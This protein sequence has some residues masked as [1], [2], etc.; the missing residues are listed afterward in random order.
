MFLFLDEEGKD[1]FFK[2]NHFSSCSDYVCIIVEEAILIIVY[3]CCLEWS[4]SGEGSEVRLPTGGH[5]ALPSAE[6][7]HPPEP[8][9]R[10]HTGER[11]RPPM[12]TPSDHALNLLPQWRLC[13]NLLYGILVYSVKCLQTLLHFLFPRDIPHSL[14]CPSMLV[15]YVCT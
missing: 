6:G 10:E 9:T 12:T 15:I 14:T 3:C 11:T 13:Y 1:V 4:P 5:H 7:S 2:K 8:A